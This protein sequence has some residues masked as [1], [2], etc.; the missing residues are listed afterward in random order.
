MTPFEQT[1]LTLMC[2]AL[3]YW[4]GNKVGFDDGIVATTQTLVNH[5]ILDEEG[6]AKLFS[7]ERELDDE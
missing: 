3:S 2:M 7:I 5:G 1:L 6:L 4:W